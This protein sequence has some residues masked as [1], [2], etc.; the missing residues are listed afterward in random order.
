MLHPCVV[1]DMLG[2]G[3]NQGHF[4]FDNYMLGGLIHAAGIWCCIHVWRW[5]CLVL[6][7]TGGGG[8]GHFWFDTVLSLIFRLPNCSAPA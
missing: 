6:V 4:W 3:E 8:G 7:K 2:I 1:L 5:I